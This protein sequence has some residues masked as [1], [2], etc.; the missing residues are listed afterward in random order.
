MAKYGCII[1]DVAHERFVDQ[2]TL[3]ANGREE[4]IGGPPDYWYCD[5]E[6]ANANMIPNAQPP[7]KKVF[8]EQPVGWKKRKKQA[9]QLGLSMDVG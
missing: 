9:S 5:A 3:L 6:Y 8:E 2:W 4:K 1:C 7:P